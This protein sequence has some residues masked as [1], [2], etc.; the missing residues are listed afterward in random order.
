MEEKLG[1]FFNKEYSKIT[2]AHFNVSQRITSFFQ[3]ML[4]IYAAPLILFNENIKIGVALKGIVFIFIAFVG[5][6]VCMY[7]N[8]LRCESLLYARAVN[9]MRS[10]SY[11]KYAKIDDRDERYQVLPIQNLK[12][13]FVDTYQFIWI[14]LTASIINAG[15][16]VYGISSLK[17][18]FKSFVYECFSKSRFIPVNGAELFPD[19]FETILLFLILIAIGIL[20]IKL[21][22]MFT[23]RVEF[24]LNMYKQRIGIDIDGVIADHEKQ[25]CKLYNS[26][27]NDGKKAKIS[28]DQITQIPVHKIDGLKIS[29]DQEKT[30]FNDENYWIYMPEI[31]DASKII[32]KIHNTFGLDVYI[33]SWRDWG[34]KR[35]EHCLKTFDIKKTTNKWL[36]NRAIYHKNFFKKQ[37]QK[38]ILKILEK[39][40]LENCDY[41]K[42]IETKKYL[43][44][45]LYLEKGNYNLPVGIKSSLYKNRF[46]YSQKWR[47]KYFVEDEVSKAIK[48]S[49]I[50]KYV[51]L[52][53]HKYNESY[54]DLPFNVIRV[55]SWSEIYDK[56]KDLG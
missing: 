52:I 11:D 50:C 16:F 27:F 26:K 34:K 38:Y 36:M 31:K 15:Y 44:K 24:G 47:I 53:N 29:D 28:P 30:I 37:Y 40:N 14:V 51:F 35:S 45:K 56:I 6:F 55:Y 18:V 19:V 48:L 12:P 54:N 21:Y 8:Q 32:E 5:F 2:D 9:A 23:R 20:Q 49:S 7:V 17:E 33:F 3:Y 25:F 10:Y 22:Y 43:Y 42:N 41:Y 13:S 39:F 1:D 4:A 46:F